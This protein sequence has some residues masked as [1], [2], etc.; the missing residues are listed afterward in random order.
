MVLRLSVSEEAPGQDPGE[1]IAAGC[2]EVLSTPRYA[3]QAR[4]LAE[5]IAALPTPAE[6]VRTLETLTLETLTS[7]TLTPKTTA[8][9]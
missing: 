5:Q 7:K 1:V 6:V 4:A 2:R 9:A 3:K 8:T